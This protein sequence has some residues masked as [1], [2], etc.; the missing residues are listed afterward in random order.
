MQTIDVYIVSRGDM[1]QEKLELLSELWRYNIR[2]EADLGD[3]FSQQE[4]SVNP[5]A[6][7]LV[8]FKKKNYSQ[9]K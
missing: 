6:R 2:A 1:T 9:K 8:T 7:F 4:L 5:R 3:E